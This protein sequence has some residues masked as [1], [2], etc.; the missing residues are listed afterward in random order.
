MLS[1]AYGGGVIRSHSRNLLTLD[2]VIAVAC[3][4]FR[5]VFGY[6]NFAAFVVTLIMAAGLAIYRL[7]PT[8]A[9][10][11]VWAGAIFQ[12]AASLPPDLSNL[13]IFAVLYASARYGSK[14]LRWTGLGSAIVGSIIVA[15]Y[16]VVLNGSDSAIWASSPYP[17]LVLALWFIFSGTLLVL[18][19]TL[20]LLMRTWANARESQLAQR[21]ALAEVAIEQ[22]RNRI[23]RDMHDIVAHSLAVVIAQADGAR[24]VLKTNPDVADEALTTI[25]GTARAALVDVRVLLGALRHNQADGPEANLGD[26]EP[27]IDQMRTAGLTIDL[28]HEGEQVILPASVQMA[29]YRIIQESLTNALRH[30]DRTAPVIVRLNWQPQHVHLSVASGIA[31]HAV[32]RTD[33]GHGIMGMR[34]RPHLVGGELSVHNSDGRFVVSATIPVPA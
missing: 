18:S 20:G 21:A 32:A 17:M 12:M 9:L 27:L 4:G 1:P 13:A 34:E 2:I 28:R 23:A 8:L 22:E 3:F 7:S 11:V 10:G 5:A 14:V 26:L 16:M 33:A 30:G 25:A 15:I 31:T 24:Y 6:E 19:W 29:M